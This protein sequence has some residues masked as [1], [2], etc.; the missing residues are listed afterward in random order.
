MTRLATVAA[1]FVLLTSACETSAPKSLQLK[2]DQ[3]AFTDAELRVI[4]NSEIGPNSVPGLPDP[5]RLVCTE[6]SPDVAVATATSLSTGLSIFGQGSASFSASTIAALAQLV[7][8]TA[9]IQLL[10]DKMYQTCL[11]YS[12][13]AITGTTYTLIMSRVDDTI[14]S[15]LLGETAGGAFGR[16]LAALGT[17]AQGEASASLAG[18]PAG[19]QGISSTGAELELAQKTVDEKAAVVSQREAALA[20]NA[21]PTDADRKVLTDAKGELDAAKADRDRLLSA[22]KSQ[23]DTMA[24]SMAKAS[25]VTA[26]GG[27]DVRPDSLIADTLARMQEEFL[28]QDFSRSF[29]DACLVEMS[30]SGARDQLTLDLLNSV[31]SDTELQVQTDLQNRA[32]NR[33]TSLAA[34]CEAHLEQT[35]ADAQGKHQELEKLRLSARLEGEATR[36]EVA[37]VEAERAKEA[38]ALAKAEAAKQF[39]GALD[40]CNKLTDEE[41]KKVCI[42]KLPSLNL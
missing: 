26:G 17:E 37:K 13:G 14:V 29:V 35:I 41:T 18:L 25:A 20:A 9:S 36:S 12:N 27:L 40:V 7:E 21:N 24:K 32:V 16:S 22:L 3:L 5:L 23:A 28:R 10:R 2:P 8:R 39:K 38:A 31:R 30:L 15:L 1:A 33:T 4:T 19:I 34:F 42:A 11:A 6:P